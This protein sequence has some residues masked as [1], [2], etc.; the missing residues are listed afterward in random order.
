MTTLVVGFLLTGVVGGYI[1]S[2]NDEVNEARRTQKQREERAFK[3]SAVLENQILRAR[4]LA[5][6]IRR[7]APVKELQEKTQSYDS[8]V[9]AWHEQLLLLPLSISSITVGTGVGIYHEA[10]RVDMSMRVMD[11]CLR[12]SVTAPRHA[13]AVAILDRCPGLTYDEFPHEVSPNEVKSLAQWMRERGRFEDQMER[14]VIC[15]TQ[16]GQGLAVAAASTEMNPSALPYYNACEFESRG[17]LPSLAQSW[18]YR[19]RSHEDV[20]W[21]W[22]PRFLLDLADDSERYFVKGEGDLKDRYDL[23]D[24]Y[25]EWRSIMGR[26][27]DRLVRHFDEPKFVA[28]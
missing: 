20:E 12:A 1:S 22:P 2:Y 13:S 11:K 4:A 15:S 8:S 26:L 28:P 3:F 27:Y 24:D 21:Q 5:E 7:D 16:F 18:A 25:F 17:P 23:P 9:E 14:A 6:A 19:S 10:N